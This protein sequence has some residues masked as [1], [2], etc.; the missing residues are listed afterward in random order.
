[1]LLWALLT[2]YATTNLQPD[3]DLDTKKHLPPAKRWL[4]IEIIERLWRQ[5]TKKKAIDKTRNRS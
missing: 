4:L 2:E 5:L 1:M 3:T